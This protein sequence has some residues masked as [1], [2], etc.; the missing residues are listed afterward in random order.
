MKVEWRGS[1]VWESAVVINKNNPVWR[2]DNTKTFNVYSNDEEVILKIMEEW[3]EQSLMPFGSIWYNW[4]QLRSLVMPWGVKEV[5]SKK[6][7]FA[8]KVKREKY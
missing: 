4:V 1:E 8:K 3:N 7:L 2:S 5:V 6:G